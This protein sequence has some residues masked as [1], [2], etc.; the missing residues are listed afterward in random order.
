MFVVQ[1]MTLEPLTLVPW[2]LLTQKRL[3]RDIFDIGHQDAIT[4]I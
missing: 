4:S 3:L 1:N 2:K